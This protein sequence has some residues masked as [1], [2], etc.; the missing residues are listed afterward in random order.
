M[1]HQSF[2]PPRTLS[3]IEVVLSVISIALWTVVVS[4]ILTYSQEPSAHC[5]FNNPVHYSDHHDVCELF[6][7][8]LMLAFA[9][10]GSWVLA[11]LATLFF[12]IRSPIPPTTIF[13]IEAPHRSPNVMTVSSPSLAS[14][15]SRSYYLGHHNKINPIHPNPEETKFN[16]N[17]HSLLLTSEE[18]EDNEE[19]GSAII[20]STT[21]Y[22]PTRSSYHL[23]ESIL[24]Q[25]QVNSQRSLSTMES[26]LAGIQTI[27]L[28]DLPIIKVGTLSHIDV[29][30]LIHQGGGEAIAK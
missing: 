30:F 3:A 25:S 27:D 4:L 6:H 16:A 9:A 1:D 8:T 11:L 23:T 21:Y 19:L 18:E 7:T 24:Y 10:V 29:S 17:A 14:Q 28:D 2:S 5:K 26:M 12:L 22:Q 20:S 15:P 13:T